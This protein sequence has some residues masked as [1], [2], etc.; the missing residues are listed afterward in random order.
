[1][2]RK[3]FTNVKS[4]ISKFNAFLIDTWGDTATEMD[5]DPDL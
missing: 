1:M 4:D 5:A 3:L 2:S